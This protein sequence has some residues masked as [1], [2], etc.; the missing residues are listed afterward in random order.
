MPMVVNSA[1]YRN[2]HRVRNIAISELGE[3]LA[4][5]DTFAWVGLHEPDEAL[6]KQVQEELG[7]HDLAVE[8]A[9]RAH[10]RPKLETYG[11]SL[12]VVLHTAQLVQ[13]TIEFGETLLFVAPRYVV[14]VR[15]GASLSYAQVRTR[16]EGTPELLAK[17]AGY[18]LYAIMDF[19]VDNYLPIVNSYED[20]LTSIE[21]A[22][23]ASTSRRN[24]TERLYALKRELIALRRAASPVA[25]VCNTLVHLAPA[26]V[27]EE[28]RPYYRDIADHIVRMLE[29]VDQ[30]RE[31]VTTAL[32][33]NLSMVSIGQNEVVKKLAGWAAILAV[34]T[35]IASLYGMNFKH[36]PEL[37]WTFGYPLMLGVTFFICMLVYRRLRRVQWL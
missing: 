28:L 10:Q 13:G 15:H 36:M 31:L 27:S 8:D 20:E 33:V 5:P 9:H 7:L 29:S 34:P 21:D 18:V 6:M 4:E 23:F 26:L 37:D 32:Q 22:I 2:G 12:F 24:T 14:S 17:G 25:E 35:L 11:D 19:V 1:V 16:C 30:M 3:A